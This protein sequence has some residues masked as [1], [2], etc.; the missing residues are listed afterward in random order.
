ME[1]IEKL[2]KP[3][4]KVEKLVKINGIQLEEAN[5]RIDGTTP[6]LVDRFPDEVKQEIED[7]QAGKIQVKKKIRDIDNETERAIH[8]LPNGDIGFPAAGFK[9]GLIESTSFVGTKDFSKKLLRGIQIVNAVDGLIPIKYKEQTVCVHSVKSNTKH[10]PQFNN[11][12]CDLKIKF[13]RNNISAE[14]LATL[15]NYAGFYY[16]IGIWSPRCK[17]GGS[18]GMYK[19]AEKK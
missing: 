9:N 13:D 7:K 1:K 16:G 3:K 14:D 11:W 2:E 5:F 4:I 15:L 19:L 17:S 18:Y 12:S 6:L 10:S 8:R